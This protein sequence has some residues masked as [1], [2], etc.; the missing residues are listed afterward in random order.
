MGATARP[1]AGGRAF[2]F[3]KPLTVWQRPLQVFSQGRAELET[4]FSSSGPGPFQDS[5][6]PAMEAPGYVLPGLKLMQVCPFPTG[7]HLVHAEVPDLGGLWL[8]WLV[9]WF[10]LIAP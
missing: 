4:H 6:F 3:A 10:L 5:D 8:L 1:G 9:A 2:V 7:K